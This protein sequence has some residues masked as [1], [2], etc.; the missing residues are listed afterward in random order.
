MTPTG[1]GRTPLARKLGIA[2]ADRVGTFAAPPGFPDLVAPR[3]PGS[4]LVRSG[5]GT[6]SALRFVV[7]GQDGAQR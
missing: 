3:L 6:W 7:R 4:R 1:P 2:P 5:D